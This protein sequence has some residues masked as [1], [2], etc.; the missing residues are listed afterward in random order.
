MKDSF[1]RAFFLRSIHEGQFSESWETWF[2]HWS[3]ESR[4]MNQ[5]GHCQVIDLGRGSRGL[6]PRK[7]NNSQLPLHSTW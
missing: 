4:L 5:D 7:H 3:G 1:Q 2:N 6:L